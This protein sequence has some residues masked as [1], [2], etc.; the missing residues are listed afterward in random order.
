M[1]YRKNSSFDDLPDLLGE[2]YDDAKSTI[3]SL[4]PEI[5]E[6][7]SLSWTLRSQGD[8]KLNALLISLEWEQTQH[9]Q[10]DFFSYPNYQLNFIFPHQFI[11]IYTLHLP[12]KLLNWVTNRPITM[13][14]NLIQQNDGK[15]GLIKDVREHI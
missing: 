2:S 7:F 1:V 14:Q 9:Y 10:R 13:L 6:I 8:L 12:G 11:S 5:V 4:P 15:D 3:Y